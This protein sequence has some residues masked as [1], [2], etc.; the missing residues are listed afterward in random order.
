[1]TNNEKKKED[2]MQALRILNG[3]SV[4]TESVHQAF[5]AI[6]DVFESY[7][8]SDNLTTSEI[9]IEL[10]I[11]IGDHPD[12][13]AAEDSIKYAITMVNH[14]ISEEKTKEEVEE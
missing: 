8:K 3:C 12:L 13:C 1:M 6:R 2:L 4:T 14:A 9:P 7:I 10:Y 5:D 11:K